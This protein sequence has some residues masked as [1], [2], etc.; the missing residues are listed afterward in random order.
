LAAQPDITS[1]ALAAELLERGVKVSYY[2]VWHFFE[3]EGISFKKR[4]ARQRT[5]S[6]RRR[7]ATDTVEALSNPT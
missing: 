4:P 6:A 5:G 3:R 1:R 2:A 7:T